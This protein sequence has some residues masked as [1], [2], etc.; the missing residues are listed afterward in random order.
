MLLNRKLIIAVLTIGLMLS[1]SSAAIGYD[2]TKEKAGLPLQSLSKNPTIDSPTPVSYHNVSDITKPTT[3]FAVPPGFIAIPGERTCQDID[4]S[5]GSFHSGYGLPNSYGNTRFGNKFVAA[6]TCTVNTIGFAHYG[7]WME[8]DPGISVALWSGNGSGYPAAMVGEWFWTYADLVAAPQYMVVDLT[9]DAGYPNDFILPAGEFFVTISVVADDPVDF[10]GVLAG[11]IVDPPYDSGEDIGVTTLDDVTWYTMTEDGWGDWPPM[12]FLAFAD[13]CY[14]QDPLSGNCAI[15][16]YDCGAYYLWGVGYDNYWDEPQYNGET[17]RGVRFDVA[18][19]ET[20][21]YIQVAI[22]DVFDD[23]GNSM[24]DGFPT[25]GVL[26][27]GRID[28]CPPH[29]S[30]G[31]PDINN[32]YHTFLFNDFEMDWWTTIDMIDGEGITMVM[33]ES[34]YVVLSIEGGYTGKQEIVTL[35]DDGTCGTGHSGMFISVAPGPWYHYTTDYNYIMQVETCADKYATCGWDYAIGGPAYYVPVPGFR[36]AGETIYMTAAAI[37]FDAAAAGCDVRDLDMW[38]YSGATYAEDAEIAFY[39]ATGTDGLPGSRLQYIALPNGSASDYHDIGPSFFFETEFWLVVESFATADDDIRLIT[40]DGS[41]PTGRSAFKVSVDGDPYAWYHYTDIFTSERNWYMGVYR[42]CYPFI[43]RTCAPDGDWPTMGKDPMRTQSTLNEFGDIQC[44]LTKS[45]TYVN[46]FNDDP[47]TPGNGCTF[48]QPIIAEGYVYAYMFNALVA[49]DVNTG[50]QLWR[51]EANY[52]EIG[53]SCRSTPTY[54]D[55]ALYTGGGD[56]G[57]F[58][59]FD[60]SNGATLWTYTMYAHAQYAPHVILDVEGTEVVFVSDGYGNIYGLRTSDGANLY[61]DP[62]PLNPLPNSAFSTTGQVHKGL[63]TDGTYLYVGCDEYLTTPN[64]WRLAVSSGGIT[65]D[66]SLVDGAVEFSGEGVGWQLQEVSAGWPQEENSYEGCYSSIIYSDDGVDGQWIYFVGSFTPQ[67]A[68]PV[69]NGGIIYKVSAD[70][71]TLGW[72]SEC[73]G[74]TN[75]TAGGIL[76]DKAQVIYGG[77]SHWNEGGEYFGPMAFAKST[78]FPQWGPNDYTP[79]W[80]IQTIPDEYGHVSQ[81]GLLT[82]ETIADPADYDW[83]VFGNEFGYWNFANP[84]IGEVVWHRRS[85][86]LITYVT[87]PTADEAGHIILGDGPKLICM[88]NDVPRQRLHIADMHPEALVPFGLSTYEEVVFPELLVNTGCTDLEIFHVELL[89]VD[90]GTFPDRVSTVSSPRAENISTLVEKSISFHDKIATVLDEREAAVGYSKTAKVPAAYALPEYILSLLEPP[91]ET[92]IPPGGS[93]DIRIAINGELIPRGAS[94]FYAEIDSDDPDYFLDSAYM[95]VPTRATDYAKPTVLLTI[96]GGCL[97]QNTYLD[98]GETGDNY[99]CVW[100]STFIY[101]PANQGADGFQ[102]D[103]SPPA[104]L[105]GCDGLFYADQMHRVAM[106]ATDGQ[107]NPTW[108]SILPDPFPTCDFARGEDVVLAQLS[109]DEGLNYYNVLGTM[110]NYAYVD[111]IEDHWLYEIDLEEDPPETLGVEWAWDIQYETGFNQPY[112]SEMTE[113]FAFKAYV[114]EYAVTEVEGIPKYGFED[115]W[116]FVISRHAVFSRYGTAIPGLFVGIVADWDIDGGTDNTTGYSEEFSVGWMYNPPSVAPDLFG[117]G[118]IKVPFGPGFTSLINT[119]D[120][121]TAWY[122]SEEPGFDSI[123]HWMSRP[124]T[125]FMNYQ[126]YALGTDR[127][128]WN[129][130]AEL[131]LPAWAFTGDEEDPVPDEAFDT[132]GY[133]FFGKYMETGQNAAAVSSYSYMAMLANRFCGFG[134]GDLNDDGLINLVDL[135]YLHCFVYKGGPG[136]YP[137]MHLGDVNG[138]GPVDNLDVTYM[139][140]WYFYGGPP[141]VGEWALPQFVPVP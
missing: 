75:G 53:G 12:A 114:T 17:H 19:P 80:N 51:R 20:L 67:N 137:F 66:W 139:I 120:A 55:G 35:S 87:G 40:D 48:A 32:P 14:D 122:G 82:C 7:G 16:A 76:N 119:V 112:S 79:L 60:A 13:V 69:H 39:D 65:F 130:I 43:V 105:F 3:G 128:M 126:P 109:P 15:K 85:A 26:P 38:F 136:P 113:G 138:D 131:N 47:A 10:I 29:P 72:A 93:A 45:W 141:P 11:D 135:V 57:Y 97:Y 86:S 99:L 88:A 78:G 5:G 52:L 111:S 50:V 44:E 25:P 134:R 102:I 27:V 132:Y 108:E 8:G 101:D 115:F 31:G 24:W 118:V 73:N 83:L 23:L 90:N 68:S 30:Q 100:N 4:P 140:N 2:D 49:V 70:G 18:E 22:Y 46:Y 61:I 74:S 110:L 96:V 28:L 89:D 6:H 116:N 63:T 77:W 106:H 95:D 107:S 36:D 81:P 91:D 124:S 104:W 21:K 94:M 37:R 62:D 133:A 125:Q 127:R 129:S 34:F 64:V 123:Y 9:A 58:S 59:K 98:F 71:T 103:G 42:C 41:T 56:N 33:T 54:H 121:T 92:V 117:A 1:F 84:T